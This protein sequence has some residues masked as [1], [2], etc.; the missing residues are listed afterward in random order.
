V[1]PEFKN[2][3]AVLHSVLNN[4]EFTEATGNDEESFAELKRIL[5]QRIDHLE[6]CASIPSIIPRAVKTIRGTD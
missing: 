5:N 6:K 2:P 3:I 4:L 1:T